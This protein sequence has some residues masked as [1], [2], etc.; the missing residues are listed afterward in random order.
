FQAVICGS[1]LTIR[2]ASG[3]ECCGSTLVRN[4]TMGGDETTVWSALAESAHGL[5]SQSIG[6]FP[7]RSAPADGSDRPPGPRCDREMRKA[8]IDRVLKPCCPAV[9]PPYPVCRNI[10]RVRNRSTDRGL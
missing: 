7:R 9:E 4:D 10:P 2:S 8:P 3:R 5:R 1:P 6:H